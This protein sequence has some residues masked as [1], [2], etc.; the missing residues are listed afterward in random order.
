MIEVWGG[1]TMG[2]RP[3]AGRCWVGGIARQLG[4]TLFNGLLQGKGVGPRLA[5]LFW[6]LVL[7]RADGSFMR[8]PVVEFGSLELAFNGFPEHFSDE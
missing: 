2:S 8:G 7:T 5:H 1:C 6:S 4:G 3:C